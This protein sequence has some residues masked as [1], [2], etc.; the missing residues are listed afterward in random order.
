M[1]KRLEAYAN[2][3]VAAAYAL[4]VAKERSEDSVR[5][6]QQTLEGDAKKIARQYHSWQRLNFED[7][8]CAY[9]KIQDAQ[10]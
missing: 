8:L 2:K 9:Q 6:A 10:A 7:Q 3:L 1:S 4:T 5:L